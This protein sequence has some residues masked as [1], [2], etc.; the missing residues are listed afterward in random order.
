MDPPS[1]EAAANGE[2]GSRSS[3]NANN[4]SSNSFN[5]SHAAALGLLDPS[6]LFG[7]RRNLSSF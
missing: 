7:K 3:S 6:A 4:N 5:A 2:R 1:S